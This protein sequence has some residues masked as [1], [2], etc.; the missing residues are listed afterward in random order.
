MK[1]KRKKRQLQQQ[2]AK[3]APAAEASDEEEEDDAINPFAAF[4]RDLFKLGG[5]TKDED[6]EDVNINTAEE[7]LERFESEEEKRCI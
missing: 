4:S 1:K 7:F 2:K 6:E 3:E 5:F